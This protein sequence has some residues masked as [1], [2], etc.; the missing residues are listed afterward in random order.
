MRDILFRG[1]RLEDNEWIFGYM[2]DSD[3]ISNVNEIAMPREVVDKDSIGQWTGL[4]DYDGNKIFEG[5]IV[6]CVSW[7]EY[8]S[9]PHTGE[10]MEPFRR[11]CYIGFVNGGFKMIEP[12]PYGLKAHTC[13][14]IYDGD[15]KIIGN[16]VDNPELLKKEE[17][18]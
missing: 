16:L 1:K 4:Y 18:D 15:I 11:I 17:N 13:D 9:N 3:E 10:V 6:E 12:M 14:I 8:F 7:N 5:D 2:A